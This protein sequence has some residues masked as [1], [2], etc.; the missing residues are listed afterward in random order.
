[1][2]YDTDLLSF[3]QR[4]YLNYMSESQISEVEITDNGFV[5]K[6][7]LIVAIKN[8]KTKLLKIKS[9]DVIVENVS[10]TVDDNKTTTVETNSETTTETK[11]E[12]KPSRRGRRR[13]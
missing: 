6:G 9:E 13:K 10:N 7:N 11:S 12:D 4:K 3:Y 5:Y 2:E 1:M 8:L